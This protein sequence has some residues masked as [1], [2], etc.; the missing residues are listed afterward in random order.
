[1]ALFRCDGVPVNNFDG[2]YIESKTNTVND[3]T[4]GTA[5]Y[6]GAGDST[7]G[8]EYMIGCKNNSTVRITV[9]YQSQAT[10]GGIKKDGTMSAI[11]HLTGITGSSPADI[12]VT[13]Y[14]FIYL[15][16]FSGTYNQSVIITA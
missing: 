6:N 7:I 1:M 4:V 2:K 11:N 3:I 8:V 16:V 14:D 10:W 12:N 15:V 9:Q 13:D 5:L